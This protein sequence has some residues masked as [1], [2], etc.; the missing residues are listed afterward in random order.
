[1]GSHNRPLEA[2]VSTT[3]TKVH[4]GDA[5]MLEARGECFPPDLSQL[6]ELAT[7]HKH[8]H[9]RVCEKG[10]FN[11]VPE[12]RDQRTSEKGREHDFHPRG[13]SLVIIV[14][15]VPTWTWVLLC[16]EVR[17]LSLSASGRDYEWTPTHWVHCKFKRQTRVDPDHTS[18]MNALRVDGFMSCRKITA[19]AK[20]AQ[21][22]MQKKKKKAIISF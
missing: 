11:V 1:M 16:E 8:S 7:N 3:A 12:S 13:G 14:R 21:H 18:I 6:P 22:W 17:L 15:A 20:S 5:D 4:T 2:G 9:F 10:P 19:F